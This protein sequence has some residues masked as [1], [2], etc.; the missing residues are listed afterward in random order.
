MQTRQLQHTGLTVSR[1][2]LGTMTF[3][4][5]VDEGGA[6][7]ILD[8]CRDAGVDFIDTA[9][10]YNAG[11]SE[12]ML[13]RLLKGR[14]EGIVL[15]TKVRGKMGDGP[16]E[17]GL[18]RAAIH[19]ALDASLRRLQTGYIDLYYLHQP[20]YAT[21]IEETLE[22]LDQAVRAGKVRQVGFSNYASWQAVGMLWT[23]RTCGWAPPYVSQPMYNLLARGIEQEFLPMCRDYGVSVVAYNPLAGGLLT[24]KQPRERPEQLQENLQAMEDGPLPEYVLAECDRVWERLRGVT[25]KYNR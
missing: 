19:N 23:S 3:G 7:R 11:E 21:P 22:A 18:G 13:G 12:G 8:A 9:N 16:D 20:D 24:G 2:C 14:R 10:V 1:A 17:Q 15:A 6:A 4:S 5:Q 25:P